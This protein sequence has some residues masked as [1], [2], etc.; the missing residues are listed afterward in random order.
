MKTNLLFTGKTTKST[1]NFKILLWILVVLPVFSFAI[2]F[3]EPITQSP[4][5]LPENSAVIY[6]TSGVIMVGADEIHAAKIIY[7]SNSAENSNLKPT[8][9]KEK[10]LSIK[11]KKVETQKTTKPVAKKVEKQSSFLFI[12]FPSSGNTFSQSSGFYAHGVIPTNFKVQ[13]FSAI[14]EEVFENFKIQVF[15]R[16]ETSY[17]YILFSAFQHCRISSLRA[18]P[19]A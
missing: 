16:K 1:T 2:E 11:S 18:P 4:S 15:Q 5:Q 13:K 14:A 12:N 19:V 17:S 7:K 8:T 3:S 10:A 6:M 9:S